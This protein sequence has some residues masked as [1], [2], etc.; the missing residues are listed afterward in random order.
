MLN[1]ARGN[2]TLLGVDI[3]S[4]PVKISHSLRKSCVCVIAALRTHDIR[5]NVVVQSVEINKLYQNCHGKLLKS[6]ILPD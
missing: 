4:T 5:L 3:L 2:R 6:E 1:Y